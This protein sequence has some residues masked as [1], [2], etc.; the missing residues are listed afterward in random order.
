MNVGEITDKLFELRQKK[1]TLAEQVKDTEA[2]I[3]SLTYLA[4]EDMKE[5]GL[6]KLT[7]ASGTVS[8]KQS[9]LYPTVKDKDAFIEWAVQNGKKEMLI[10]RANSAAFKEY[11]TE[12]GA[13]PE[14][15]DGYYA[16][17]LNFKKK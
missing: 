8:L 3:E 15:T 10:V 5:L 4:I 1:S 17:K 6:D 13:Y 12:M 14:G 16:D 2:E 9:E 11:F 7:T